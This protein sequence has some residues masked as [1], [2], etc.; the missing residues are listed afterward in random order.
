MEIIKKRKKVGYLGPLTKK[1][2]EKKLAHSPTDSPT[3][4]CT[5]EPF[6]L[7]S[8]GDILQRGQLARAGRF[9]VPFCPHSP[10]DCFFLSRELFFFLTFC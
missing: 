9:E 5:R 1:N 6:F 3:N 7:P 2:V 4:D 8:V 10:L